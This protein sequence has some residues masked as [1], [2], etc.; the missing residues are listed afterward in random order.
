METNT[1]LKLKNKPQDNFPQF[2]VVHHSAAT[3]NQ[4]V[5]SIEN[6]HLSLGWEG[7]GYQFLIDKFG[8]V[9]KGRPEHYHGAH[10]GEKDIDGKK[11]N[12]K[13]IGICVIGDFDKKLPTQEQVSALKTLL[14]ELR[15]RYSIPLEKIV[16]HR[17]FLGNPPYKS[18]FGSLLKDGWARNL[19][20]TLVPVNSKEIILKRLE[21]IIILVKEL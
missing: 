8:V 4:S 20:A 6:Y 10:V 7:V 2:I 14:N 3:E 19:V 21:E 5:Q 16:P 12:D 15:L 17:H 18:C 1:Y 9:W 13:S 11:I